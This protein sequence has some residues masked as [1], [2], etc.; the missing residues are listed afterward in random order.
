MYMSSLRTNLTKLCTVARGRR[1]PHK[2]LTHRDVLGLYNVL[3]C[4]VM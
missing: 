2:L 3:C 1:D 4:V